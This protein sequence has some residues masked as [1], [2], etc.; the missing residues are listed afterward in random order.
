MDG[1]CAYA[2]LY[3]FTLIQGKVLPA[4]GAPPPPQEELVSVPRVGRPAPSK[5]N[6]EMDELL[7]YYA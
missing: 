4:S 5:T 7:A 1:P 6:D 3:R 2:F